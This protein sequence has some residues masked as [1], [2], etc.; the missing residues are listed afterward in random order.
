[1]FFFVADLNENTLVATD[2][3]RYDVNVMNRLRTAVYW[4]EKPT[5][6]MR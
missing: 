2:G 5:N 4:S 1:M 6:V 3:G